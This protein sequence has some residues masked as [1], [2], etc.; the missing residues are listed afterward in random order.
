MLSLGKRQILPTIQ[1]PLDFVQ[2]LLLHLLPVSVEQL[3]AV[4]IESVMAGRDHHAAVKAICTHHKADR[5]CGGYME[6]AGIS[7]GC[8]NTGCQS[9]LQHIA[10]T[11]CI[12]TDDNSCPLRI[13]IIMTQ[14]SANPIGVICRQIYTSLSAKSVRT[15]VISHNIL[16]ITFFQLC[17]PDFYKCSFPES[18]PGHRIRGKYWNFCPQLYRD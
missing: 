1:I 17:N 16:P 18:H 12:F 3:D 13:L 4:V 11:A 14:K 7:T 5:G 6:Q 15:K 10:G 9:V 2:N 8:G